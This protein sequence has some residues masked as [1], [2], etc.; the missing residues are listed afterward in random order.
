MRARWERIIRER[1]DATRRSFHW[2]VACGVVMVFG[3]IVLL[4]DAI[5]T[6]GADVQFLT[7]WIVIEL[8][9]FHSLYSLYRATV[10]GEC[11]RDDGGG[12]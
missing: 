11:L 8:A 10:G 5:M 3:L 12:L 2:D 9:S 6:G 4:V 7:V 1:R